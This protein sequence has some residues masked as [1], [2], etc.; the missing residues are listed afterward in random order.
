MMIPTPRNSRIFYGWYVAAVAC[1]ANFMTVGTHF[2]IFNVFLEPLCE[3]NGWTRTQVNLALVIGTFFGIFGQVIFGTIVTKVGPRILMVAGSL[4]AG[5]SFIFIGRAD[6]LTEL[7][8]SYSLLYIGNMSYGGIVANTVVSNWFVE[9]RGKALG[10]ATAGI[11]LSGALLPLIA[12]FIMLKTS[13]PTTSAIIGLAVLSVGPLA[14]VVVRDW[15]EDCGLSPDGEKWATDVEKNIRDARQAPTAGRQ[16]KWPLGRL[17]KTPTFY[18]VGF[19]Y[20]L[21]LC[22]TVGVM[23]QLK[24][25]F[26]DLGFSDE[27][28]MYFM[29]STALL[30]AFGKFTWGSLCDRFDARKVAA[31]LM[32][33]NGAGLSLALIKGSLPVLIC[34]VVIFGFAMGGIMSTY[35]IIVANLFGRESFAPVLKYVSLFLILQMGGFLVAGQSYDRFGSYDPA[36][37]AFILLDLTAAGLVFTVKP[38]SIE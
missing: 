24:P 27:T 22:G 14:W 38:V 17:L 34:F 9:K 6:T 20:G 19:A 25:R 37:A 12:M 4:L 5:A 23:S 35:P 31:V 7:Y 16:N 36:Y 8:T 11:S 30:G 18:K 32:A 15:P 2:Y 3:L 1:V 26:S 29:A 10:L 13:L 28:A 33:M 21:T